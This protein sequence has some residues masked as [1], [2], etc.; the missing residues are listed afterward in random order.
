M[1]ILIYNDGRERNSA[2]QEGETVVCRDYEEELANTETLEIEQNYEL[3]GGQVI[4]VGAERFR[5]PEILFQPCFIGLEQ[6][7]H[8]GHPQRS[9]QQRW[10]T[11]DI[12]SNK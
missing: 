6:D 3:P 8:V 4:T 10:T 12:I 2:R 5:Y 11:V 7:G 1:G 9:V